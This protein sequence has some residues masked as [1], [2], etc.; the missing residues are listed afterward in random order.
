MLN[1]HYRHS[2]TL[3]HIT[4]GLQKGQKKQFKRNSKVYK[5]LMEHI[6]L[7]PLVMITPSDVSL[8]LG[9][10]DERRKFI[11][12]VISQYNQGYLDDLLNYNRAMLQRNN[13]LKQ[14]ASNRY[15]DQELLSVWDEQMIGYGTRIHSERSRFVEQL[16]PLFQ[17]YYTTI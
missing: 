16:I 4:C 12:G 3:E 11:D 10:S 17:E 14:Y 13:L 8:I 15:F 2:G 5:K 6:G 1:G 9:G 7:I